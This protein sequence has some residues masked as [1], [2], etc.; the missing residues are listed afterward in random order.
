M[1]DCDFLVA[2]VESVPD[3][4]PC[5][6]LPSDSPAAPHLEFPYRSPFKGPLN[7]VV[8]SPTDPPSGSVK[9]LALTPNGAARST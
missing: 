1:G 3:R 5:R 6:A 8:P 4:S 2:G 7:A 9:R